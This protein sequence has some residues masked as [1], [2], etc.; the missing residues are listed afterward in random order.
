MP[1]KLNKRPIQSINKGHAPRA[2]LRTIAQ[3]IEV[4]ASTV[5]RELRRNRHK[6]GYTTPHADM[7]AQER[8]DWRRYSR[9]FT[10]SLR[11]R[12]EELLRSCQWSPEQISGRLRR[13][14][15]AMVG[16]STLY[17]WL[18]EDKRRGGDLYRFC[19][20]GLRYRRQRLAQPK[21]SK[22]EVATRASLSDLISFPLKVVWGTWKWT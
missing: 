14:G 7:L 19:R 11:N 4:S 8:I 2:S 9:R 6:Q 12:A 1:T 13:E 17:K 20:H 16:K 3:T 22:S 15:I 10:E 5:S 21:N 18:H